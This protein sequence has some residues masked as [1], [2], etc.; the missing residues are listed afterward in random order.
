[1][2]K[3]HLQTLVIGQLEQAPTEQQHVAP[4]LE[5]V[6]ELREADAA[7]GLALHGVVA[8]PSPSGRSRAG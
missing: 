4:D 2:G 7:A 8:R 1:M 3:L 6:P 5:D